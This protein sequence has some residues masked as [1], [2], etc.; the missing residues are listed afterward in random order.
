[1]FVLSKNS[2]V[3]A[4][5][6]IYL[7]VGLVVGFAVGF[8]FTNSA[9]RKEQDALRAEVARL[10]AGGGAGKEQ[11]A[12]NGAQQPSRGAAAQA[13]GEQTQLSEDELRK[14]VSK[15]DANPTDIPLQRKLG[16]G[17]YLYALNVRQPALLNDAL[18]M[19][20]RAH[21]ADPKDFEVTALIGNVLFD[22]GQNGDA[23]RI[24]EA[25]T[26]FQKAL[27]I[28]PDNADAHAAL[29]LTYYFDTPPDTQRAIKEYR[30]SL[31]TNARHEV[32]LQS[33]SAALITAGELGEAQKRIEELESINPQNAALA[34]LRAQLAQKSNSLGSANGGNQTG[35]G[36]P[37]SAARERD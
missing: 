25:R 26:Y 28:K 4:Q 10:R 2:T 13:S 21:D 24:S 22:M 23:A 30:K 15:G 32:A 37:N 9:N 33:L 36:Q 20:K 14:A 29:G 3:N 12:K 34:D 19:L 17:L 27:E 6:L 1:M 18:R 7:A 11:N 31:A 8:A 5:K 16:Q 35:G